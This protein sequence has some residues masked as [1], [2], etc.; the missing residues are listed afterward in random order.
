MANS[1]DP[2]QLAS[3]ATELDLH[4]LPTDLDLLCL[5]RQGISGCSKIRVKTN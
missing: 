3:E 2:D 1:A 5:P 4:G